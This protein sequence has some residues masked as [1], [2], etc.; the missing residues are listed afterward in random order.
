MM[1]IRYT[2]KKGYP[3]EVLDVSNNKIYLDDFL[4]RDDEDWE[5]F[6]DSLNFYRNCYVDGTIERLLQNV[7]KSQK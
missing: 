4:L 5:D 6:I 3:F 1:T 7:R 2:G